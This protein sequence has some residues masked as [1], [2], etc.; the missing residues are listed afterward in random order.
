MAD[1][2]DSSSTGL[3]GA[4]SGQAMPPLAPDVGAESF[5]EAS[6]REDQIQNAVAFLSHPKVRYW[7]L[8]AWQH[9]HKIRYADTWLVQIP[10]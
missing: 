5:E 2:D 1:A 10:Y 8:L 9:G 4:S 7:A 3:P 6:L